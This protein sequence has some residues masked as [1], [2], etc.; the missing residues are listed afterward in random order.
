MA[1]CGVGQYHTHTAA[2]GELHS[3]LNLPTGTARRTYTHT[4]T[5][6]HTPIDRLTKI[7]QLIALNN[8]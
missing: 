4:H 6:T 5:H 1:L 7:V 3:V 8:R 2:E